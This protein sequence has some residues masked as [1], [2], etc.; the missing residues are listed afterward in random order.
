MSKERWLREGPG[1]LVLLNGDDNAA[2]AVDDLPAAP[3]LRRRSTKRRVSNL[4]LPGLTR[5]HSKRWSTEEDRGNSLLVTG[6]GDSI[7]EGRIL[8]D[9]FETLTFSPSFSPKDVPPNEEG[10]ED[11]PALDLNGTLPGFT[12]SPSPQSF[13]AIQSSPPLKPIVE[14]SSATASLA[15]L[16]DRHVRLATAS[17]GLHTYILA[18]PSPLFTPGVDHTTLPHRVFSHLG[19][20]DHKTSQVLHVAIQKHYTGIPSTSEQADEL[21]APQFYLLRDDLHG[22]IICVVRGTQS[23][24]DM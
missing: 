4:E 3:L 7:L 10:E 11:L 12:F 6:G 1:H 14:P 16:L 5:H 9:P 13:T 21:Y 15:T 24:H 22:E 19:G 17:Y 23:L 18:P 2:K 8:N 20:V